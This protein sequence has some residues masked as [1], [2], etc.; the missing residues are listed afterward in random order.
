MTAH[1]AAPG[2]AVKAALPRLI[3]WGRILEAMSEQREALLHRIWLADPDDTQL[4]ADCRAWCD[5]SRALAAFLKAR[6][7][8]R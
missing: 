4:E 5:L 2:V 8:A 3:A 7:A 1:M 6:S